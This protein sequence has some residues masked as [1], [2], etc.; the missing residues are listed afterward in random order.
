MNDFRLNKR[1]RTKNK[2]IKEKKCFFFSKFYVF[3]S[4]T[5]RKCSHFYNTPKKNRA[6]GL[7]LAV[8]VFICC[9]LIL[10]SFVGSVTGALSFFFH[11]HLIIIYGHNNLSGINNN[12]KFIK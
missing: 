5:L 10:I 12:K 6:L 8:T 4:E 9:A 7:C 1:K 11:Q 3:S 2:E